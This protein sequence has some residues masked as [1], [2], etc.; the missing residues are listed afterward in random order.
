MFYQGSGEATRLEKFSEGQIRKTLE[1]CT[2]PVENHLK[3]EIEGTNL[4]LK[5]VV[6]DCDMTTVDR[7]NT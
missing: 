1:V 7:A 2:H 4:G 6:K 3:E 5:T